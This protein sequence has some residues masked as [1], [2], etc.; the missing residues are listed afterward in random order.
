M[1][2]EYGMDWNG[3]AVV[4]HET[5]VIP[6]TETPLS[7]AQLDLLRHTI[8]PMEECDHYGISL[9]V[10]TQAFVYSIILV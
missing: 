6:D 1:Q 9:Y 8:N 2:A 7:P 10:A 5:V 3:P 4:N